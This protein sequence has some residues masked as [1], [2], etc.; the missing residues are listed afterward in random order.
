ME[1]SD[2]LQLG[3]SVEYYLH[4]QRDCEIGDANFDGATLVRDLRP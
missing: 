3:D 1:P 4:P 2:C